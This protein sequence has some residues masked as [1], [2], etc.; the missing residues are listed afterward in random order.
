VAAVCSRLAKEVAGLEPRPVQVTTS[1]CAGR[2]AAIAR[3]N[4][5]ESAT[6]TSPGVSEFRIARN[7]V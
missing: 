2:T 6:K 7:V 3:S 5:A 1:V 4:G